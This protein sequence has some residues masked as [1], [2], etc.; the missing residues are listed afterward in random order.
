MASK[1]LV[2]ACLMGQAVRYDGK[3]KPFV[4]PALERWKEEGRLVV[5]CPEMS[6]GMPVPRPP[7]ELAK[8][9]S[10][11]NILEKRGSVLENTGRD[12]SDFFRQAAENALHLAQQEGCKHALLIDG[13]PSCGSTFIYDGTFSGQRKTGSGVTATLLKDNGIQVW[14]PQDIELLVSAI[15]E[16]R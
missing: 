12:V 13:S 14:T 11:R 6:A 9:V 8:G 15:G 3:A 16:Q 7:A 2:S 5:I 1:I 4:H 10:A